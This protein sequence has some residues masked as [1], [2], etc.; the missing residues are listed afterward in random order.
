MID[1]ETQR[2]F[3]KL[4]DSF[5]PEQR[6]QIKE[7]SRV[8]NETWKEKWDALPE[9]EK[10]RQYLEQLQARVFDDDDRD[11]LVSLVRDGMPDLHQWLNVDDP[12]VF[13]PSSPH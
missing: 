3:Q 12:V 8:A 5:S 1:E 2:A 4:L 11:A 7:Q 13:E 6:I 9:S 10:K